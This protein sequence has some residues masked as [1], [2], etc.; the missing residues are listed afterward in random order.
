MAETRWTLRVELSN[1]ETREL[2]VSNTPEE[3]AARLIDLERGEGE[4]SL[5]FVRTREGTTVATAH[6][7]EAS[8]ISFD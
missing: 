2:A 6:I 7:V 5:P 3:A 4:F 1:G 8:V